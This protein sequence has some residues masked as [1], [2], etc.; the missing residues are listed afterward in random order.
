MFSG[1]SPVKELWDNT[2][3]TARPRV[4]CK[5]VKEWGKLPESLLYD[6]SYC[7]FGRINSW[8]DITVGVQTI[9]LMMDRHKPRNRVQNNCLLNLGWGLQNCSAEELEMWVWLKVLRRTV[10]HSTGYHQVPKIWVVC[11]AQELK[12]QVLPICLM[13]GQEAPSWLNCQWRKVFHHGS[14]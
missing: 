4:L 5:L 8:R 3:V 13:K 1:S 10:S 12:A 11:T 14:H 7:M 6:K 2:M 9:V